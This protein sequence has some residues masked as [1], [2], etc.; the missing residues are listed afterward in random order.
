MMLHKILQSLFTKGSVAVINLLIL[1]ITSKF[2]G[3]S[4][5]GEISI[6]I[7]NLAIIQM[8][9][10]VYTG[11]SMVHFLSK[12]SITKI[13]ANGFLFTVVITAI[14]N[15]VL[16]AAGE[17]PEGFQGLFFVLS[18]IIILNTFNCVLILSR[19]FYKMYNMLSVLQPLMLLLGILYFSFVLKDVTLNAF[20][21]PLIISFG[22]S[23]TIST[24]VV[25]RFLLQQNKQTE[26]EWT[27]ILKNGIFCQLAVLMHILASRLSY[28]LLDTKPDVGLYS[29]ASS[30]IESVLI[31][32]NSVTPIL[33]S[34]VAIIGKNNTS[35]RLT[36]LF[37]KA[38]FVF[39][40]A[41]IGVLYLI[42]NELF[43][44]LL[45]KSFQAN[46]QLML[47]LSPGII[48]LSFSGIISHYFSGIGNLKTVS[49]YNFF[50]FVTTAVLAPILIRQ[51]GVNGAAITTNSA[52][53]VT[54]LVS[55]VVFLKSTN[56]PVKDLF[57]FKSDWKEL[58][59]IISAQ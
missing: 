3:I 41:A 7:L 24:Y 14:S 51:Y 54:F 31:I 52:Y 26:F 17:Q 23:F 27:P 45:G 5:R 40:I 47:M 30:L 18:F 55:V 16:Y 42:P 56:T 9:N 43:T 44:F 39:S 35:I 12:F 20:M 34:R 58:K 53:F 19:E 21:W 29:T 10:E 33:L 13:Y 38:C 37:A 11:Y 46:K 57:R 59:A 4:T 6:I 2:L 49:F 1:I 28:Y 50:G 22:I 25:F 8:V 36:L 48:F 32:T 15:A